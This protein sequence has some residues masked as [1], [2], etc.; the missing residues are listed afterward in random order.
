[1][2]ILFATDQYL[3]TI[4]GISVVTERLAK[5]LTK[6]GNDVHIIAPSVSW[7]S[8]TEDIDGV[9]I[10]RLGSISLH[11]GKNVRYS[12]AF[13]QKREIQTILAE[14]KPDILHIETPDAVGANVASLGK[15]MGIPVVGTCHIMPQNIAAALPLPSR[16]GKIVGNIYMRQLATVF[17]TLDFVT[18]P[19]LTGIS[20]LQALKVKTP[21]KVLSNGID[22]EEFRSKV[23]E[24]GVDL[25]DK[26]H[27]PPAPFLL[28][29]GR[30]DKEKRVSVLLDG[31]NKVH[32]NVPLVIAGKGPE[33]KNFTQQ[34]KKL[35]LEDKVHFI[36]FIPDNELPALYSLACVFIM[37]STAELQSL[38]TME[39]MSVGLP[40]IGAS[41]GALPYLIHDNKN[42]YLFTPDDAD[43]LAEKI[44][45]FLAN[46]K[47][48]TEMGK[49]SLKIIH[50]HAIG[51]VVNKLVYI[52][53][54]LVRQHKTVHHTLD[55]SF[56]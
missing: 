55:E 19:T 10:H 50:A 22:L 41:A 51:L 15:K 30:L 17:N 56:K 33:L 18:A 44:D 32:G 39:A 54:S 14:V 35:G 34:V 8:Y 25:R 31:M 1:M 21:M 49:E 26:Y 45:L 2:T 47:K 46:K 37:P 11:K 23:N 29:V 5:A 53:Q 3:P 24:A 4:G 28:Y 7:K 42:G 52:Y 20:I 40:I 38:V 43:D 27:L 13:W 36:G 12:P 9:T 6:K 48:I 16:V